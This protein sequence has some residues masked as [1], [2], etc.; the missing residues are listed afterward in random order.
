MLT[1]KINPH[2]YERNIDA[3]IGQTGVC[4][5]CSQPFLHACHQEF[6]EMRRKQD[7]RTNNNCDGS[8]PHTTGEVKILSSG[9]CSNLILCH[10]C[11]NRE[12][13]WRTKRN[14]ELSTAYQFDLPA[15]ENCKVYE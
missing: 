3:A 2:Q 11:F 10:A 5:Y 12:L 15:W 1:A 9:G 14:I 13:Q 6:L 4:V 8:G 7:R